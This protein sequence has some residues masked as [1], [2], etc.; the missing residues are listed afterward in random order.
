MC[1]PR[2]PAIYEKPSA[3]P[4]APACRSCWDRLI[5][6]GYGPTVP[7]HGPYHPT[8][9]AVSCIA[10][11]DGPSGQNRSCKQPSDIFPLYAFLYRE[12]S[13]TCDCLSRYR[14]QVAI[15]RM[16]LAA[17]P[18]SYRHHSPQQLRLY[19]PSNTIA[20]CWLKY[21][22]SIRYVRIAIGVFRAVSSWRYYVVYPIP[23]DARY[24]AVLPFYS[25]ILWPYRALS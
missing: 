24:H 14:Q 7:L 9:V 18:I 21:Y 8:R 17:M 13:D 23:V 22:S 25:N 15:C 10:G 19:R 20:R 6:H 2:P 12:P 16:L 1:L 3:W 4:L 5:P 11:W